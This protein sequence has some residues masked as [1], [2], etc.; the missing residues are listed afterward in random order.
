MDD[1]GK[2][3]TVL[4]GIRWWRARQR[5]WRWNTRRIREDSIAAEPQRVTTMES[6][7]T[8]AEALSASGGASKVT[9]SVRRRDRG[10]AR[11][12]GVH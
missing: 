9:L 1:S 3:G 6:M 5:S 7:S 8:V 10:L 2:V 12:A 11:N 4:Y